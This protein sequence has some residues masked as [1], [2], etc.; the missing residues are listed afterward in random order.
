MK[1]ALLI[2]PS[3]LGDVL[4]MCLPMSV[5]A[6]ADGIDVA[7]SS[8]ESDTLLY[9]AAAF[10]FQDPAMVV[11]YD[12][13]CGTKNTEFTTPCKAGQTCNQLTGYCIP[14]CKTGALNDQFC[15]CG[16]TKAFTDDTTVTSTVPTNCLAGQFCVAYDELV[17]SSGSGTYVAADSSSNQ[18]G[19]FVPE[20]A[21]NIT[22][23]NGEPQCVNQCQ[24]D[25]KLA[26]SS[27][28]ACGS[29]FC[30]D[31]LDVC[32]ND[33]C[34]PVCEDHF[35]AADTDAVATTL[36]KCGTEI[37]VGQQ[38]CAHGTCVDKCSDTVEIFEDQCWCSTA[39]Y[40]CNKGQ[41]CDSDNTNTCVDECTVTGATRMVN[42]CR[43]ASN[44]CSSGNEQK[45]CLNGTC[46]QGCTKVFY[47]TTTT[48]TWCACG[49]TS[50]AKSTEWCEDGKCILTCKVS[51]VETQ[52]NQGVAMTGTNRCWCTSSDMNGGYDDMQV[53]SRTHPLCEAG[54]CV[55]F[56]DQ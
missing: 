54:K 11:S 43:C 30:T 22:A 38:V 56:L 25:V 16:T 55:K 5:P 18:S 49:S 7:A 42:Q 3:V 47:G 36:C 8:L 32:F 41:L 4:P 24:P 46:V 6:T 12:C 50:C 37:C 51:T 17:N 44:I 48:D 39:E 1:L 23:W 27:V 10:I 19:D 14:N 31:N 40:L 35:Q 29:G 28:C 33:K 45:Y 13:M 15:S 20:L 34:M 2:L 52:S 53:C 26:S 9:D 21:L